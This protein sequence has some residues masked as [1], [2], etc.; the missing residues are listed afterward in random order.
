MLQTKIRLSFE[1]LKIYMICEFN[2]ET[3]F[4][5]EYPVSFA[6]SMGDQESYDCLL[7]KGASPNVQDTFGNTVL[8][9]VVINNRT[10]SFF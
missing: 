3:T 2:L 1:I 8:H 5:G 7:E 10:V 6:A 4:Y 9:I